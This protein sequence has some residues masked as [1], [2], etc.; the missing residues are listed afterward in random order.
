MAKEAVEEERTDSEVFV[1]D[2]E[3]PNE[4]EFPWVAQRLSL[5]NTILLVRI[6]AKTIAHAAI[7]VTDGYEEGQSLTEDNV[8]DVI[9]VL[10]DQ[11]LRS[12]LC[13]IT[14]YDTT[15]VEETYTLEKAITVMSDF[16]R[17]ENM[18]EVLGKAKRLATNQEFR[19]RNVGSRS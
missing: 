19:E 6:L 13:I 1:P 12:V 3:E 15:T 14:G 8:M 7:T 4:D 5:K 11:M 17:L 2:L 10:D 16:W 18:S 9:S